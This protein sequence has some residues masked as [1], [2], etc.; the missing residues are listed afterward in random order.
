MGTSMAIAPAAPAYIKHLGKPNSKFAGVQIGAITYSFRSLDQDAE[1]ILRCCVE[2]GISAIE[3]MGNTA[4]DFAGAPKNPNPRRWRPRRKS[5]EEELTKEQRQEMAERQRAAIAYA[6]QL[7]TWRATASMEPFKKL[8]KMFNGA[9]VKIYAWKPSALRV[10]N[11]DEEIRYA[12]KVA[13]VLGASHATV[14]LPGDPA[15]SLRLGQLAKKE[16]VYVG[17]HGHLQQTF[18]AWDEA[19]TQSKFNALNA[20]I[21]HYVA[22]GF[23]PAPLLRA[24]HKHIRSIHLKD[25]RSKA[26]GQENMPW[27]QGD[28]PL[29]EVLQQMRDERYRFPGSIEL[30]YAIP[31]G[32]DAIQEV[33]KCL[34]YCRRALEG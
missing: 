12:F 23:D 10:N 3:L 29:T 30:E 16:K 2:S 27:G 8:R 5:A 26:N 6:K 20:D 11:T 17:Y 25:R 28:T 24:K 15:H 14:E 1:N 21:G 18:T 4:E 9:G 33:R 22:A 31:D 13:R 32:S 34:D 19:L 7:A